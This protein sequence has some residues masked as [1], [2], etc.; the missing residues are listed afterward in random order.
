MSTDNDRVLIVGAGQS[1]LAAAYAALEQGL[2]PVLLEASA[3]AAGSWPHYYDSLTLFSP[4]RYSSLPGL[5]FGGDGDRYPHRDEVVA[6]LER[7]AAALAGRGAEIRTGTR[8][9]E[10]TEAGGD[11]FAVRLAGGGELT[12]PRLIAATGSFARP[13]RPALTGQDGFTGQIL[14]AAG[15]RHPQQVAGRRVI[16]VGAG[17]SAVQIAYELADHARVTLASRA[18]IRFLPQRPLGRD[19]HHWFR[20]TGF[21]RLPLR[22]AER[23]PSQPVLDHGRYRA[24]LRSGRLERRAMFTRLDGD[25]VIWTGGDREHA[26]VILLATGYRPALDWLARLGA[27]TGDGRPRQRGGLSSTHRGLGFVGLEWQRTPA[28]NSLRGVGADA[29]HLLR[30]LAPAGV[31]PVATHP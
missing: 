31:S 20:L 15:Y 4:A 28:S 3:R 2:R 10:V 16:V 19:V 18:P 6:Y 29:R 12:A 24:A 5:A 22:R 25:E 30:K 26:D 8:V 7:Y 14:H 23:P 11:G 9:T 17:N 21:D 27:L 13:H 1:G